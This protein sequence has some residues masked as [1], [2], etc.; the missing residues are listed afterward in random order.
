MSLVD[1]LSLGAQERRETHISWVFLFDQAHCL[2]A[3]HRAQREQATRAQHRI[4]SIHG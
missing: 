1:E 2:V 3:E 4:G